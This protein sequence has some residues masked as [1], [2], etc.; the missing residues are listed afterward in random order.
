MIGFVVDR[1]REGRVK[2]EHNHAGFGNKSPHGASKAVTRVGEA[3]SACRREQL[4]RALGEDG[5]PEFATILKVLRALGVKLTSAPPKAAA[6]RNTAK[7]AGRRAA[8]SGVSPLM[9][10]RRPPSASPA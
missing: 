3:I 2:A 6:K 7:N 1:D 10:S 8:Q 5:N 4:Y 9:S